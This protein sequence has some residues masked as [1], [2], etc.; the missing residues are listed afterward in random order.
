MS[1]KFLSTKPKLN[2]NSYKN[3]NHNNNINNNNSYT[4]QPQTKW[5][6]TLSEASGR[7]WPETLLK[8]V[9][10]KSDIRR[11]NMQRMYGRKEIQKTSSMLSWIT[12]VKSDLEIIRISY[13]RE[14]WRSGNSK[15]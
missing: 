6:V 10:F 11:E 9:F 3:K 8:S 5:N 2:I 14:E 13:L 12:I 4:K 7:S 1:D 15:K